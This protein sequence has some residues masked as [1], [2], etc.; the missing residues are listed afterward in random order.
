MFYG[1]FTHKAEELIDQVQKWL[2][3]ISHFCDLNSL[4]DDT[5]RALITM[6]MEKP[7]KKE[8]PD[9]YQVIT[10]PVDMKMI[11]VNILMDKV[12]PLLVL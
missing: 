11:E 7:S 2:L 1:F 6:F 3:R 9:Y 12:L 10:D 5:G 8:Y 4:Q